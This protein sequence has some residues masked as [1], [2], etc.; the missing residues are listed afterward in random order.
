MVEVKTK[1]VNDELINKN[2]PGNDFV[3]LIDISGS[4]SGD[5]IKLVKETMRFIVKELKK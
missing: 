3:F 2:R 5:R 4:M 1:D